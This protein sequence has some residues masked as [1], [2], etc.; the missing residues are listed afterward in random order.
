MIVKGI[1]CQ[2]DEIGRVIQISTES[3]MLKA[4]INATQYEMTY[5]RIRLLHLS[6]TSSRKFPA[7]DLTEQTG[8]TF[9]K[10]FCKAIF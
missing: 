10:Q 2:P 1:L 4:A 8:L 7:K 9:P 5:L 3:G 6:L